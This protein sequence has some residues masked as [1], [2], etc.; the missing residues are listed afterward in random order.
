MLEARWAKK[1]EIGEIIEFIDYVFSKAHRPHDFASLLPKLYGVKGDSAEHHFILRENGKL[2]AAILCYPMNMHMGDEAMTVLGIGSVSTHPAARGQGYMKLL[3][4]AADACAQEIG[5][6]FAVLSG[7][8]QRYEHFGY[9]YGGYQLNAKLTA[10]NADH[11]MKHIDISAWRVEAMGQEHVKAAIALQQKQSCFCERREEAYLDILRSWNNEPFVLTKEGKVVGFGA[12][13]RNA[14]STHVAELML[15]TES[16]FQ[17]AM[18]TLFAQY[19]T[20]TTCAAPWETERAAWLSKVCQDFGIA[21]NHVYKVYQPDHVRKACA[22]MGF[23]QGGFSF[24]GFA[25]PLP[26]Y[27]GPADCV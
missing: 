13:R 2:V 22:S 5:A 21:K 20:L 17:A 16:D 23:E 4:D 1:E 7:L 9:F 8:R 11:A 24:E 15:E 18:K 10:H 25:L 14:E 19:G 6:D 27:I 12:L 26:L 3:M